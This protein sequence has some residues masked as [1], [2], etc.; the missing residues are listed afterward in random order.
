MNIV[1]YNMQQNVITHLHLYLHFQLLFKY[2]FM[3]SNTYMSNSNSL[4]EV[5]FFNLQQRNLPSIFYSSLF[6]TFDIYCVV[7]TIILLNYRFLILTSNANT[8][9]NWIY[10]DFMTLV[11]QVVYSTCHIRGTKEYL[12]NKMCINNDYIAF[13][14]IMKI[15]T[16]AS[17]RILIH[18]NSTIEPET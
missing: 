5:M 3:M 2:T 12:R 17:E 7:N 11:R 16:C 8:I 4:S 18:V 13:S 9:C 1:H 10:F 14:V 15:F 6:F